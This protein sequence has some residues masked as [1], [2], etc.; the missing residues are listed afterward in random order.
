MLA[1]RLLE[2]STKHFCCYGT[3]GI[4]NMAIL[5]LVLTS[6]NLKLQYYYIDS[7]DIL[8]FSLNQRVLYKVTTYLQLC[9]IFLVFSRGSYCAL[10]PGWMY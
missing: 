1:G 9:L 5:M 7:M 3:I 4:S 2:V 6:V 8:T 10:C